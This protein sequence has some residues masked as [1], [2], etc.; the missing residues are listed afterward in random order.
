MKYWCTLSRFECLVTVLCGS[1]LLLSNSEESQGREI[2][3]GGSS[4]GKSIVATVSK[5]LEGEGSRFVFVD[6]L[7]LEA[8]DAW[9]D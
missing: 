9:D 1:Q 5:H 4:H 3:R 2:C 6:D 8:T 7:E